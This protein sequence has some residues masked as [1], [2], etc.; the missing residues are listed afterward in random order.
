MEHSF[1]Y[2]ASEKLLRTLKGALGKE[3]SSLHGTA[4]MGKMFPL[5]FNINVIHPLDY[6]YNVKEANAFCRSVQH[7]SILSH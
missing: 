7:F 3:T 2:G 4:K 5:H 6:Q 1:F